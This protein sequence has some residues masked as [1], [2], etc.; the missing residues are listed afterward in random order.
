MKT[1]ITRRPCSRGG[2]VLA[3]ALVLAAGTMAAGA[4]VAQQ[5]PKPDPAS[6]ER[7]SRAWVQQCNRC[8]NVRNPQEL[9]D[10]EWEVSLTHMRLIGNMPGELAR[11]IL[12]FLKASN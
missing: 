12:A 1:R 4:A 6:I 2:A 9:R 10:S 8:H 11:D 5:P 7:G 3:R